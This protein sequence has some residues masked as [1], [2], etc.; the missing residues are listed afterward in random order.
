MNSDDGQL[1]RIASSESIWAVWRSRSLPHYHRWKTH[2]SEIGHQAGDEPPPNNRRTGAFL[3]MDVVWLFVL[4]PP[5]SPSRVV[6]ARNPMPP[7]SVTDLLG[8]AL[9]SFPYRIDIRSTAI[10]QLRNISLSAS[11][12]I[13]HSV[14]FN[15]TLQ[16]FLFFFFSLIFV[17]F[18]L[19]TFARNWT[20]VATPI[21][22]HPCGPHFTCPLAYIHTQ[23]RAFASFIPPTVC[24]FVVFLL[25]P[26]SGVKQT[27]GIISLHT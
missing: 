5:P 19:D 2:R 25:H 21:D 3:L 17:P 11:S 16:R 20:G 27:C 6:K 26:H 10:T 8:P 7:S 13:P 1:E 22:P 14:T 23:S 15:A 12:L 9:A 4:T 24:S 18:A